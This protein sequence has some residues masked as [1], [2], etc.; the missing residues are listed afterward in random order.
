MHVL[1]PFSS[2]IYVMH[3]CIHIYDTAC[4]VYCRCVC[5]HDMYIYT[6]TVVH[7]SLIATIY[8][9]YFTPLY[10]CEELDYNLTTCMQDMHV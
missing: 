5:M 8:A 7:D 10:I 2:Y 9:H 6:C 4:N 1:D 3:A